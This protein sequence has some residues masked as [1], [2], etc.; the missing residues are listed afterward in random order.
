[1]CYCPLHWRALLRL[2]IISRQ[3]VYSSLLLAIFSCRTLH[4]NTSIHIGDCYHPL[5]DGCGKYITK[6]PSHGY[7][8]AMKLGEKSGI[9]Y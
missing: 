8:E 2:D 4:Q 1:M 9:S 3:D 6:I 5:G 7:Q